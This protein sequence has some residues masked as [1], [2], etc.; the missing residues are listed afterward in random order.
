MIGT[1]TFSDILYGGIPDGVCEFKNSVGKYT[2]FSLLI[3]VCIDRK[4]IHF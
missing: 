3:T 4:V 2:N 1:P